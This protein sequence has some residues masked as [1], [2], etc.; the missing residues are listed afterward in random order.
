MAVGR[1]AAVFSRRRAGLAAFLL[2]GGQFLQN[3]GL[4]FMG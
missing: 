3:L 2:R 1:T 4:G